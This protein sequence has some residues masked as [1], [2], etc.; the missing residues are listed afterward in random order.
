MP[1]EVDPNRI[2]QLREAAIHA[3]L[4]QFATHRAFRTFR[5]F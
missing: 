5:V 4:Y 1:H 3:K 2:K